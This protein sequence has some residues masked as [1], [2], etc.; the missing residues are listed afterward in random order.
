MRMGDVQKVQAAGFRVFKFE[1]AKRAIYE[2][3]G[4]GAWKLYKKSPVLA[5]IEYEWKMLMSNPKHI[6]G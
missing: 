3:T 6:E 5:A 2:N 1:V 4:R